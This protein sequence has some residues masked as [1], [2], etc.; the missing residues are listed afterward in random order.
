LARGDSDPR[1][2]DDV[3]R[4]DM[5]AEQGRTSRATG[6]ENGVPDS[7]IPDSDIPDSGVP[8]SDIPDSGVPEEILD[9]L[10]DLCGEDGEP[11]PRMSEPATRP[12]PPQLH[13][14]YEEGPFTRCSG[15]TKPLAGLGLYEIQKVYRG[16]EVVFETA[17][18]HVC[19]EDLVRELSEESLAAMKGF[20]V[21][22]FK[23]ACEPGHC[24]FCG[25]PRGLFVNYT[26]IGACRDASILV[27]EIVICETCSESLNERL[28]QK[29]RDVQ[30]DFV[31]DHFP[32]VPAD[33][34]LHPSLRGLF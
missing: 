13:S 28:S 14:V 27:P 6:D 24:H 11:A 32:G 12:I 16:R 9:D 1:S 22:H 5:P 26:V 34:D 8:D 29:T 21:S 18:C 33:L 4:F 23:P 25:F 19:G 10:L 7:D 31:Q 30:S 15:C 3:G 17:L 20:L 2:D